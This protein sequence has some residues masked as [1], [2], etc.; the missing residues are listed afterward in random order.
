MKAISKL[1]YVTPQPGGENFY[2]DIEKALDG[3]IDW[4]QLRMK[5]LMY[6]EMKFVAIRVQNICKEYSATFIIND[7]VDLALLI[8]A[9]GVHLGLGD[10]PTDRARVIL[11]RDKIIGGT[12]NTY[13]DVK[14]RYRS[15]ADYV[16]IGPLRFTS[17]KSNL[18]PVLGMDGYRKI[19]TYC[20]AD[21]VYLP[22]IAI[23]GITPE[24]VPVLLT[25]GIHGIA[26][27]SAIS[28]SDTITHTA[29]QFVQ[30]VSQH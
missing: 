15:G 27:S 5:D 1:H 30:L 23:G 6:N 19:V 14:M 24:D 26:V 21:S 3:G 22:L 11:G 7:Y 16:G 4:V 10:M 13:H 25:E 18:S 28:L 29:R 2:T 9:D 8:E 20:K 17:T 12:A